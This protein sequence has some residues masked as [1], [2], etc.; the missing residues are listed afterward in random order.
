MTGRSE[1]SRELGNI[2][3]P[4]IGPADRIRRD[5][6]H[7]YRVARK[8]AATVADLAEGTRVSFY[9]T[10]PDGE[11]QAAGVREVHTKRTPSA[12][13]LHERDQ[14]STS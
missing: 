8:D 12:K 9:L 6:G 2:V 7:A 5:D 3:G 1:I 13:W 14:H 4:T 11:K 10:G